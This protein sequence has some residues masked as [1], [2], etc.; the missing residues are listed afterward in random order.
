MAHDSSSRLLSLNLNL[1]VSLRAL[2]QEG[3]VTAAARRA[4]V[5]QSA[6][7]RSLAQLREVFDDPLMVRV[8]RGMAPTPRALALRAP[9]EGALRELERVLSAGADFAPAR[10]SRRFHLMTSDALT[11]TLL[12]A[13]LARLRRQAP[14]VGLRASPLNPGA[15]NHRRT[16]ESLAKGRAPA[17]T[18]AIR[19]WHGYG[20]GNLLICHSG[21]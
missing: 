2:L 5:T 10:S 15:L 13:L 12:P 21:F 8:G 7:S 17:R 3:S 11:A 18:A 4:G 9:L 20:S 19:S 6:M 16:T 14:G 1:L